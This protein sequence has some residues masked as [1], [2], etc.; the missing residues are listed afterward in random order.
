M[1]RRNKEY[2]ESYDQ[3]S[4]DMLDTVIK[5]VEAGEAT[6]SIEM[7]RETRTLFIEQHPDVWTD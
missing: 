7:L 5:T 2:L 4:F 3:G 1:N 6:L